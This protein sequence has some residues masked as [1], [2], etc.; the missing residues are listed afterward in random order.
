MTHYDSLKQVLTDRYS[1]RAFGPDP[2]PEETI[3][4]IVETA[5]KVP[6]WCNSQPWQLTITRGAGTDRL[7]AVLADAVQTQPNAPDI[8]FPERYQG[9]YKTRRSVCGW[10]LYD[11]VGISKGDRAA[12]T[13]Q[14]LENFRFFGAPHVAIVT[15]PRELGSYGALDCGAFVTG[16]ALVAKSLGVD[17]IP[18]AAIAGYSGPVRAALNLPEDRDIVC[19]ISFGYGDADHP[20]N[21]FRTE[22]AKPDDVI[23]WADS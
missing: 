1:C 19:A 22:R 17:T 15:S 23:D 4:Q 5:Q 11:A 14:M 2:V 3:R 7:R 6:S 20:A 10:Q 18:Q 16:F 21:Q 12:S 8:P 13:K 9:V